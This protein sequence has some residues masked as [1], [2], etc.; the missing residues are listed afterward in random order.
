M[1]ELVRSDTPGHI[2]QTM[3]EA[4]M[5]H[6][7]SIPPFCRNTSGKFLSE[8]WRG[9]EG[10]AHVERTGKKRKDKTHPSN[11]LKMNLSSLDDSTKQISA[12]NLHSWDRLQVTR[13]NLLPDCKASAHRRC[14]NVRTLPPPPPPPPPSWPN[15]LPLSL[16]CTT[17]E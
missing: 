1:S 5:L 14:P 10:V 11:D 3:R 9:K 6:P 2:L 15:T 12:F 16:G 8:R 4:D 13:R 17:L 7:V